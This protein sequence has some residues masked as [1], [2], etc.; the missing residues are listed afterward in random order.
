[1]RLIPFALR[2]AAQ[3]I[4]QL[5]LGLKLPLS[6]NYLIDQSLKVLKDQQ[7]LELDWSTIH[8]QLLEFLQQ[9]QRYLL[10][11]HMGFNRILFLP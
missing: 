4:L 7:S 11:D 6:L 3:G 9:R 10:Q 8:E 2:R 5:I 1:M